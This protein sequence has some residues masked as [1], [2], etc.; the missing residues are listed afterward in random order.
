MT[1]L[2]VKLMLMPVRMQDVM[3]QLKFQTVDIL[4][5][6]LHTVVQPLG[7]SS[8]L[9]A[10]CR[11]L[12]DPDLYNQQ[13]QS[14][15]PVRTKS[16]EIAPFAQKF[17][18]E[19]HF[20]QF[21]MKIKHAAKQAKPNY[22]KLQ[23]P[24]AC[25]LLNT[26]I[27]VMLDDASIQVKL[28]PQIF[29]S[30]LGW[31][32]TINIR[33]KGDMTAAQLAQFVGKLRGKATSGDARIFD[34]NGS[35]EPLWKLY[36]AV[37]KKLFNEVYSTQN[38][39][40]ET[41]KLERY[42]LISPARFTGEIKVFKGDPGS[43]LEMSDEERA[44]MLSILYGE[45]LS[46]DRFNGDYNGRKFAVVGFH[47]GGPEFALSEFKKGTFLFMQET[48]QVGTKHR[49][50]ARR[51]QCF[52]SN[53]RTILKMALTLHHFC[54][55]ETASRYAKTDPKIGS[56]LADVK[57]DLTE[58]RDNYQHDFCKFIFS[59]YGPLQGRPLETP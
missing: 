29:I 26:T 45:S 54:N 6:D 57:T 38:P 3:S 12:S 23:A 9:E 21:Y 19:N 16:F 30:A 44:S 52:S 1:C 37:Q 55:S 10:Q 2:R 39:P 5:F 42:V 13:Y 31:S 7:D 24:F 22:W 4:A 56:L 50:A 14:G 49:R 35:R 53:V 18:E 25:K 11:F 46:V 36:S 48:A 28:R 17:V 51:L 33:L 58:L 15:Q 41:I 8:M 34:L 20:W 59:E 47:D 32:T 27:K 43:Y 40:S